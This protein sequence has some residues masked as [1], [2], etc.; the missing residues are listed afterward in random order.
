VGPLALWL[1][2]AAR[3][4]PVV[5]LSPLVGG[6]LVPRPVRLG[7]GAG[8]VAL[9]AASQPPLL[10][11]QAALL[12]APS[13]LVI[14]AKEA[15][16]GAVLAVLVAIPIAGAEGA[17][18][19]LDL[20]RGATGEDRRGVAGEM[21]S[22]L[23]ALLGMAALVTFFGIGGHLAVVGALAGSYD[24]L[25]VL[26]AP[27]GLAA[28]AVGAAGLVGAAL[29][30]AIPALLAGLVVEIGVAA[31]LRAGG[32]AARVLPGDIGRQLATLVV[33]ALGLVA[34]A[35]GAAGALR[36]GLALVSRALGS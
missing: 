6:S 7:L 13:L 36:S 17:G 11:A 34:L 9:I 29:G 35:V 5:L 3:V 33:L 26:E 32:A 20:A 31:A 21:T 16:V 8:L 2:V 15:A 10:A 19:A 14:A 23:G 24:A 18:R 4:A 28:I 1:L 27:D 30:L 25:P 12:P 22:P